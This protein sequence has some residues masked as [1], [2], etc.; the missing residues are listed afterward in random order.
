MLHLQF[1]SIFAHGSDIISCGGY[2][3]FPMFV[4]DIDA[5]AEWKLVYKVGRRVL[6]KFVTKC[7]FGSDVILTYCFLI[8]HSSMQV[9][10]KFC[11]Y[12]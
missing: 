11:I 5:S 9:L 3:P 2:I 10:I 1:V 7:L 6:S 12:K 4:A 8:G